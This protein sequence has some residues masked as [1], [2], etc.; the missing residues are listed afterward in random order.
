[1]TD[2]IRTSLKD[3]WQFTFPC[4]ELKEKAQE[5]VEHHRKRLEHWQSEADK[6]RDLSMSSQSR[7]P[8][9]RLRP[10]KLRTLSNWLS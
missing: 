7:R 4:S 6:V 5:K 10:R 3:E 8:P 1:M 9:K 2:P